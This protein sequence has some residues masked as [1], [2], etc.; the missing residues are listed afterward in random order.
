MALYG[1]ARDISFFRNINRELMGNIISEE[2]VYYKYMIAETK[3]N[4]YG[5]ASEGRF[6]A[7]PV[8]INCLIETGDQDY[9]ESDLGVD[10]DWSITFKFLRDD[11]LDKMDYD[12]NY[13][14]E[15]SNVYG[16]NLV[17]EVGDIIMYNK[18][19]YEVDNTNADQFFRGLNPNFPFNDDTGNN[20]LS[21]Q[22]TPE[23]PAWN[24]GN[25]GWNTSVICR[26][27][28]VP[29]DRVNIRLARL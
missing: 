22:N 15:F 7:D 14:F 3:T 26:T 10:F 24:V 28:Y 23:N 16:A 17:P 11:L 2:C 12:F 13:D 5:E 8:I 25:F 1:E 21:K 4:M 6:F 9:P 29:A 27:H 18:G 19:Y 20:P